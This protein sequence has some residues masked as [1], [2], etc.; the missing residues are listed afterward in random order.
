VNIDFS[1]DEQEFRAELRAFLEE[2]LPDR[3]VGIFHGPPEHLDVSFKITQEMAERGWLTQLW[4]E[5]Y[6]G[7]GAGIW[8]QTVLQEELWAYYE[9]RGGQYMGVNWIGPSIIAFGTDEQQQKYLPRIAAGNVQWAQ[10]FSEP[11]AGSDL[12]AL[13]TRA[14][15]DGDEYVLNGEKIWTSYGDYAE[16]GVLVA[17]CEPSSTRHRGLVVLLIDMNTPGIE[18]RPISTPLGKHKLNSVAM[19]DARVPASAVL[20]A[21]GDGWKVA[22]AAL[23]FE[24]IGVARY[25]RATRLIGQLE[26]MSAAAEP[27][28]R[29]ELSLCLADARIAELLNYSVVS[30]KE[31]GEI[32]S[33][34]GSA[35][36][37]RNVQLEQRV[38]A[39]AERMIGP[40]TLADSHDEWAL[41]G[42]EVEEFI[43]LAPTGTVVS[44][45]YEIQMGIIAQRGLD[46]ERTR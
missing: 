38:A 26:R 29:E 39:L 5:E 20:G 30:M 12:A 24:R 9:P 15:R 32:P 3:W 31:R 23:A 25:A 17:R 27:A 21:P 1:P 35:A 19:T 34:Q 6:G 44:G 8:R 37:V 14:E 22:M 16:F 2:R 42:G 28:V 45:A 43:R 33:W 36:R 11:G 41:E 18:V 7:N 13:R 4:P 46:L 10:L 40:E